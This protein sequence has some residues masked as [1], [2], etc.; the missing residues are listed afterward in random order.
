VGTGGG[1]TRAAAFVKPPALCR[2]ARVAVVAPA[3]PVDRESLEAGL[4]VLAGRYAVTW[5]PALLGRYRYLAG[6]DARRGA[7][8]AAA[9]AD[10]TVEAVV[11]AR[12]GYGALR[13][14]SRLWP[15]GAG[16]PAVAGPAKLLVG[17][18][19][20]TALHAA[21]QAAGH[22]SVHGP[23]VTQLATQPPG[24]VDRFFA[25]LEDAAVAPAPLAGTPVVGGVA[26]GPL[27]GGNLSLVTRLLGTPWLPPLDGAVLLLEDVGERPYR[28]DRMWTHLRLAGI[29]GRV[30]GL[31]LGEFT[32]CEEPEADFTLRDVVWGLAAET[33]LPCLG[34]LPI[35]HGRVNVP[36]ALGARVRLDAGAGTLTFLEPAVAAPRL[37]PPRQEPGA[38]RR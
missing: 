15:G 9:L 22:V 8:L 30:R 2:G 26:E 3:G 25:L 14:L 37:V 31:A 10:P 16:R 7:E 11:A 36:V 12:G 5:D 35:G 33:G 24:V 17:F 27:L 28:I 29:F 34:D 4:R 18:S 6:D 13:L 19:D 1:V 38:S 23:V 32:Q 21:L 20:I